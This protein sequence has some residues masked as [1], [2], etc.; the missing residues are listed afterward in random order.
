V[1]SPVTPDEDPPPGWLDDGHRLVVPE[2]PDEDLRRRVRREIKRFND[3]RSPVFAQ[4]RAPERRAAPLDAYVL[5]GRARLVAGLV[6]TARF[7][8]TGRG[9]LEIEELW[10]DEPLRGR[11]YGRRLVARVEDEA[12]R[13]GCVFAHVRTFSFQA[14]GFYERLGYR[15][16][17]RLDEYAPGVTLYWLKKDL[18]AP[19]PAP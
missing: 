3:R 4:A 17:G 19:D 5:D 13:R 18:E 11:G 2:V 12:R 8:W 9:G 16:V 10:V 14:R 7:W 1:S 6:G 15:V